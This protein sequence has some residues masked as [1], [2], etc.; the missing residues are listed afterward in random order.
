[1]KQEAVT[2]VVMLPFGSEALRNTRPEAAHAVG[3]SA[4]QG[5]LR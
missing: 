1:M 3:I 2:L 4:S 5:T